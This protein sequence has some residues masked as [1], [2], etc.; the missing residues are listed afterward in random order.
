MW[1]PQHEMGFE[2]TVGRL[3]AVLIWETEFEPFTR[4]ICRHSLLI[5]RIYK[6]HN[7]IKFQDTNF[8]LKVTKTTEKKQF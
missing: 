8:C 2:G 4:N 1:S 3:Y 7:Q 6:M 5:P